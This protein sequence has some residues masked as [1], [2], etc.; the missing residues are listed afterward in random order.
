MKICEHCGSMVNFNTGQAL[1]FYEKRELARYRGAQRINDIL[2][3]IADKL[4]M[5][6]I[7]PDL[8]DVNDFGF[9]DRESFMAAI[10][11]DDEN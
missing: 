7:S 8:P 11:F 1:R 9:K 4:D 3:L 5:P 2:E 10:R 6:E